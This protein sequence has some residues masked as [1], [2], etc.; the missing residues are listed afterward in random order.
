MTHN[1]M[2]QEIVQA[3]IRRDGGHLTGVSIYWPKTGR[4]GVEFYDPHTAHFVAQDVRY[5]GGHAITGE[6]R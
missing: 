4:G 5:S 3:R 2:V 1:M 6:A